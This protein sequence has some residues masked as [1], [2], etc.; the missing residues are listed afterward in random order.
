[1]SDNQK[2]QKYLE[3]FDALSHSTEDYLY[4]WDIKNGLNWFFGRISDEFNL[5]G[6]GLTPNTDQELMALIYKDDR[7]DVANDLKLVKSGE[8][9]GHDLTYRWTN[10]EGKGVWVNCR[11]NVIEDDNGQPLMLLG[12]V[13]RSV[14][15][16]KINK[17]TGLFNKNKMLEDIAQ[18]KKM[19][20]SGVLLFLA[21]DRIAKAYSEH[22][23]EYVEKIIERCGR[24]IEE[25]GNAKRHIYHI[26]E[27]IF[28]ICVEGGTE[29]S[30]KK[31]YDSICEKVHGYVTITGLAIRC[32]KMFADEKSMYSMWT[33]E[34]GEAKKHARSKLTFSTV[35][36]V[37]EDVNRKDLAI[38]LEE[39]VENNFEGF[40]IRYQP[41]VENGT[42]RVVGV[43][44]L[45]RFQSKSGKQYFPD[46]FLPL[47]EEYG[48]MDKASVWIFREAI[49][50]VKK[51]RKH[52]P[53]L[54]ASVNFSFVQLDECLD[55][56]IKIVKE[57]RLPPRSVGVEIV[58]T[59]RADEVENVP[60]LTRTC[61]EA[62][63]EISVD[64]FGTGYSNLALLKEIRADEIKI[65]RKFITGIKKDSYSYLLVNNLVNF[66]RNNGIKV[67]CEGVETEEDV[68][69]LSSIS[70][71]S[72]QGYVFDK[73]CTAEEFEERY[74]NKDTAEYKK[75]KHFAH[76]MR[77]KDKEQISKF[78]PARILSKIGVGL[79]VL[80][81]D[82]ATQTFDMHPDKMAEQILGMPENLTPIECN[83]FWFN[84]IKEGYVGLVKEN[85]DKLGTAT[86]VIQII[87][88]WIHPTLGEILL[89]F[90]GVR[91]YGE[92]E[93]LT[94][95][96]MF[97]MVSVAERVG[98]DDK[99]VGL[100]A[101]A[102]YYVQSK[103]IDVMINNA[104]AYM[105]ID[106]T[107][108]RVEGRLI[109]LRGTESIDEIDFSSISNESGD[110][111]Y[112]EYESWWANMYI[113]KNK[114]G[115]LSICNSDYLIEQ[116]NNGAKKLELKYS[117]TDRYGDCHD[118]HKI[119]YLSKDE[120]LDD[121]TALCVI[122]DITKENKEEMYRRNKESV[123]RS[124]CDEFKTIAHANLD[125]DTVEFYREDETIGDWQEGSKSF[126]QT[127]GIYA[128]KF[129]CD[130]NRAEFKYL[131]SAEVLKKK[132][133]KHGVIRFEYEYK[134][135][136]GTTT[137]Y[138]EKIKK[139]TN[140]DTGYYVIIGTK[141][142]GQEVK[143]RN[144]LK[145]A[146][147][148]AYTDH[149]TGLHNQQ[150][151]MNKC[152]EILK[153]KSIPSSLV[154]MDIDNFKMV[155]DKYGHSMGDKILYEVGRVLK[156]ETRGKDVVGRYGG[157]EFVILL[158]DI[159][160]EKYAISVLE[161]IAYR[162]EEV[163]ENFDLNVKI[164][165][166]IG[167]AFTEQ[168]GYDYRYLKEIADDRLYIA[169][170]SG[171]NKIVTKS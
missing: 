70:P 127:V 77:K 131:L 86:D 118:Y 23:K 2:I 126:S 53:G 164:S 124:M 129:V 91:A 21:L 81:C 62:G 38:E 142:I 30:V 150:G 121:I 140:N 125:N 51:W 157:D 134:G 35:N 108:N 115:F 55:D 119:I 147:E 18:R 43:E 153:D 141:D 156:E 102:R 139:D 5:K 93:K 99:K 54:K 76:D 65:D 111:Y 133:E 107:Q 78:D 152:S 44:A 67:C 31:L 39:S 113:V 20:K 9:K 63:I 52:L 106:L 117:A 26:E 17:L 136:D 96:A 97:R 45:M 123:V 34:V 85:L 19:G 69:T 116:Y 163:C 57:S 90:S 28:A 135:P 94:V 72:Y 104:V 60:V 143:M 146:L 80:D 171:K 101:P 75:R 46:Q 95:K 103:Y 79:C 37:D 168:T 58:E 12:R 11:G 161:R 8:K 40:S 155:N 122:Y 160:E 149:L 120:W 165:A 154:F 1:M 73:P 32:N 138:E 24:A 92:N 83:K 66:A 162:I 3:S 42:F 151:L 10:K 112:T 109:D 33:K 148:M 114:E 87:F 49:Y 15:E 56:I 167:V 36:N 14:L 27:D 84:R 128:D 7:I 4:V 61:K 158:H 100:R 130:K 89:S 159:K 110:L 144:D 145:Y 41:Q 64:D 59:V 71:D 25:Y 13:S 16:N 105:E 166:S 47:M 169:K 74:I 98:S 68:L 170:K 50:Q 29:G 22:G 132:L 82:F 6:T 88:P 48:L 137:Y